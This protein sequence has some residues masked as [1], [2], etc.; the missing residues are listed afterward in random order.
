MLGF[1]SL[2]RSGVIGGNTLPQQ[3]YLYLT[4]HPLLFPSFISLIRNY[5][6]LPYWVFYLSLCLPPVS[7]DTRI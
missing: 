7:P 1:G 5:P 6:H 2:W 3:P 4:T